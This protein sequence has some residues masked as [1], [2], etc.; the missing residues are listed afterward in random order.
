[1]DPVADQAHGRMSPSQCQLVQF[2]AEGSTSVPL[3]ARGLA[4]A[5]RC[6]LRA[7]KRDI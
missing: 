4:A 3:S 5:A 1:M 6:G 7:R 2:T